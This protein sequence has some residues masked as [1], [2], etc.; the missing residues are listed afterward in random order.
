MNEESTKVSFPRGNGPS[1]LPV[2]A[3]HLSSQTMR[4][5]DKQAGIRFQR[6]DNSSTDFRISRN[7][8]REFLS[9]EPHQGREKRNKIKDLRKDHGLP[10]IFSNVGKSFVETNQLAVFDRASFRK[11]PTCVKEPVIPVQKLA[12]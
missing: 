11:K 3:Y 2:D 10:N 8:P 7:P 9:K 5:N 4:N 12:I 1:V 6:P